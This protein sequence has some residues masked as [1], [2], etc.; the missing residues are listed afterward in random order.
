MRVCS[1]E[2]PNWAT[3]S[4]GACD[5]EAGTHPLRFFGMEWQASVRAGEHMCAC[6]AA[7]K[8]TG[9][10]GRAC[11]RAQGP[12]EHEASGARA[13]PLHLQDA[14][15]CEE[16][17]KERENTPAEPWVHVRVWPVS[18]SARAHTGLA[19]LP[20]ETRGCATT[21]ARKGEKEREGTTHTLSASGY[22]PNSISSRTVLTRN[23]K[24]GISRVMSSSGWGT[25]VSGNGEGVGFSKKQAP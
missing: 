14:G 20:L 10:R 4:M 3:D 8:D 18:Q 17:R 24:G 22:I 25:S 15:L 13:R 9:M 21:C 23:S 2:E 16:R 1:R 12:E 5:T 6:A 11:V 7:H 19:F